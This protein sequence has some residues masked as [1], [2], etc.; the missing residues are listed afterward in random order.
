M[1]KQARFR[2]MNFRERGDL[3]DIYEID[4]L[5]KMYELWLEEVI[6]WPR[7]QHQVELI[8][9]G[10]VLW[11]NDVDEPQYPE[12]SEGPTL[13]WKARKEDWETPFM[14]K[15]DWWL[16]KSDSESY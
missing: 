4:D 3:R 10:E 6:R 11:V 2:L 7:A 9:T 8:S 14:R 12:R 5:D 15:P 13:V 16:P 1:P